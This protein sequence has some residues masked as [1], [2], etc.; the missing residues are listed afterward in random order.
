MWLSNI[1]HAIYIR[2]YIH[3]ATALYLFINTRDDSIKGQQHHVDKNGWNCSCNSID[4]YT[5]TTFFCRRIEI[6]NSSGYKQIITTTK[7]KLSSE[8]NNYNGQTL[9]LEYNSTSLR[10]SKHTIFAYMARQGSDYATVHIPARIN[11]QMWWQ[12]NAISCSLHN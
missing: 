12:E 3:N 9:Q 6:A 4:T 7:R 2:M 10:Y 11:V 8:S 1:L 5:G